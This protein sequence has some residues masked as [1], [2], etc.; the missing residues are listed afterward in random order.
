MTNSGPRTE[1]VIVN[2]VRIIRAGRAVELASTP[3]SPAMAL[4]AGLLRPDIVNLHMPYPPGDVVARSVRG[5]PALVVTYHSDIVRQRRLLQIY[6]PVLEATLDTADRIIASTPAYVRSSLYLRGHAAKCRVVPYGV[7]AQ[8]FATFDG[9][10]IEGLRRAWS[11]GPVVLSVGVLRYYKGLHVLLAAIRQVSAQLVIAGDGPER[12]RLEALAREFGVGERVH[13][14]GRVSDD[15]L[16]SYYQAADIFVLASHLRAEA[17]GIVLLEAMAA[18][19]PLVTTELGTGTS[20]VNQHGVTGFV[21]PP[22]EPRALA[23]ALQVLLADRRLREHLGQNGRRRA[24]TDY[25]IE[26]MAERTHT[27]YHEALEV[28]RMAGHRR[29]PTDR[30]RPTNDEP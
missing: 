14:V 4:E 18:G 19:L 1:T 30:R 29:E 2:G 11:G 10:A 26:R 13:F 27:V 7:D 6:R 8:R 24:Q 5:R 3:F 22:E 12:G 21:V 28:R 17:F 25:S 20:E 15:E 16:A 9:Q 23:R